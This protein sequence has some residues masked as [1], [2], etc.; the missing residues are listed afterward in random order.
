MRTSSLLCVLALNLF[1][2]AVPSPVAESDVSHNANDTPI[3]EARR[4]ALRSLSQRP[5]TPYLFSIDEEVPLFI[6]FTR[7]G[8]LIHGAY[9]SRFMVRFINQLRVVI[10]SSGPHTKVMPQTWE[11]D[12][13]RFTLRSDT[14][15]GS[16]EMGDLLKWIA[17]LSRFMDVY[18]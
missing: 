1:T 5:S 2:L 10:G 15:A 7:Y 9:G 6:N 14:G 4:P 12:H 16:I 3:L 13:C 17:G 18:G 11:M 8:R